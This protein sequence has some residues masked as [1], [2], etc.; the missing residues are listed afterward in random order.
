MKSRI[1]RTLLTITAVAGSGVGI[2]LA[3]ISLPGTA[4][5]A[6][7]ET[8]AATPTDLI[9]NYTRVQ[10]KNG[11][12]L[13]LLEQH[14]LPL[15]DFQLVLR[16]GSVADP[17]GKEGLADIAMSLLRKGTQKRTA[18]KLAEELDF[19]GAELDVT[20]SLEYCE[21]TAQFLAKDA[22]AGLGLVSDIL[23]HPTFPEEEFKKV[24]DLHV[25][26]LA[27][28]KDNPRSVIG[29]YFNGFLF[30]GHPFGRPQGGTEKSL[31]SITR[32]DVLRFAEAYLRPNNTILAAV[33]DFKS[34]DLQKQVESAFEKWEQSPV[35]AAR[36]APATPVSGRK[37]F[38]VDKPDAVQ[39]YFQIGNVGVAKGDPDEAALEVVNTIFGG[40]FTSWL[41]TE[42]RTK[43]GLSYNAH[44]RFVT[45]TV[46]GA[47]Y[48][49]SFTKT[50]TTQKAM[51]L[52]LDLLEKLHKD[53]VTPEEIVSAQNYIRGQY[54]PNYESS[55]DLA[56]ALVELEFY[57]LDR[58]YIN[59]HTRKTDAVTPEQARQVIDKHYPRE[60]LAITM[61]GQA[62]S[63]A[64]VAAHYGEVRSKKIS[65]PGF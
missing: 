20:T 50:A 11:L 40:R 4:P 31:P 2:S 14:E 7:A 1:W 46:P 58:A 30:Q 16:T 28:A 56:G 8:A 45:R 25:D 51:D 32:G 15:V 33:G 10:L 48:I 54:P 21:V 63:V 24:V 47:F 52:A 3:P 34:K 60:N 41:M 43:S 36:Q 26:E 42:L 22:E 37:V 38:L 6:R 5:Q 49:S 65:D 35:S 23:M 27:E 19:L 59:E 12:V 61:I 17:A 13:L 62:D 53:G 29:Q 64:V 55:G 57:G 9:P 44:S 18:E 39:T